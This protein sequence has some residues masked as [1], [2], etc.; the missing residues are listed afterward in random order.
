MRNKVFNTPF[1][2][3]LRILLLADTLNT[4]ANADRLAA[5][6]FICIYGRKC[7]ILDKNLH[8][9]NEFGFSEFTNKRKKIAEAIRLSV[10][11]D[12]IKVEHTGQGFMYSINDRGRQIVR[13]IQSPYAKAYAIGAKIVCRRFANVTDEEIL[14]YISDRAAESGET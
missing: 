3:M 4:P 6:D 1:E 10:R 8:G 14:Q 12:Y 9:D 13:D 7:R 11:N 5:L 2:N